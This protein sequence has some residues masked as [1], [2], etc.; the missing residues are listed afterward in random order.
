M[1]MKTRNKIDALAQTVGAKE[2][3]HGLFY[4][5]IEGLSLRAVILL[6]LEYFN[7]QIVRYPGETKLKKKS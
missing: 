6:V 5:A 2:G 3:Q 7:L 1:R 4:G